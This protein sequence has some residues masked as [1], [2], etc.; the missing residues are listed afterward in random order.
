M[1]L[2]V[3]A[4]GSRIYITYRNEFELIRML[5]DGTKVVFGNPPAAHDGDADLAVFNHWVHGN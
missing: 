3:L 2:Y 5:L 4:Q 1:A